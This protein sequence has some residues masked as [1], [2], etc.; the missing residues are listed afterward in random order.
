[1][2]IVKYGKMEKDFFETSILRERKTRSR[3]MGVKF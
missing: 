3:A 1:M 2:I